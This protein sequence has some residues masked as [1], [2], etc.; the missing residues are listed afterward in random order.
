MR[1][2]VNK[3][4]GGHVALDVSDEFEK[5][6]LSDHM[7]T[8]ARQRSTFQNKLINYLFRFRK[9]FGFPDLSKTNHLR[10]SAPAR[11]KEHLFAVMMGWDLYKCLPYF[12]VSNHHKSIYLF[13]AW[14]HDHGTFC[15]LLSYQFCF[16]ILIAIL[17]NA[18][19]Q[20]QEYKRAL[21]P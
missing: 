20:V 1:L 17:R 9:K 13:D 11:D 3:V 2:I 16:C 5:T 8:P 12:L 19:C 15:R 18:T 4:I 14:L 6:I 21:D 7:V 10:F